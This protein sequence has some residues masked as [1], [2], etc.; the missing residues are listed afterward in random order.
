MRK[1]F[2]LLSAF[3]FAGLLQAQISNI[4]FRE[5]K[6]FHR[7]QFLYQEQS[8]WASQHTFEKYLQKENIATDEEEIAAYFAA[9]TS[10][11]NNQDGGQARLMSFQATYPR[12][13]LSQQGTWHLGSYYLSKG[14]YDKAFDYLSRR[15]LSDLPAYQQ[16]E[17]RFKLGYVNFMKDRKNQALNYL[18]PLTRHAVYGEDAKYYVGHIYYSQRKY[19][20]AQPYF[21]ELQQRNP[22]FRQ[23]LLPYMVQ[24]KFNDENYN[25]AIRLGKE[26][27]TAYQDAHLTSE[28]SK[29][30]GE[31]YFHQGQY[32][33]SIP[34]LEAY[35]GEMSAADYYQ[36]GYAYYQQK[37]YEKA[38]SLFNK[39]VAGNDKMA[40]IAYY[41]LGN[42]Y[43]QTNRKEQAL[44]AFQSAGKMDFD[45]ALQEDAYYHYAKLSYDVG[46]PYESTPVTLQK[47]LTQY[48]SG[49]HRKEIQ[50]LLV[51]AYIT[52]GDYRQA[53][54][55]LKSIQNKNTEQ[56]KTFQLANYLYATTL[57]KNGKLN[58]A[59]NYFTTARQISAND[60][61]TARAEF[62]LGEIAYRQGKYGEALN[63]F[64]GLEN[65][66][67]DFN[68]RKELSYQLGYTH[69]KLK[70]FLQSEKY[71][72]TYLA[73]NP[74]GEFKADARM[75]LADSYVG[76]RNN[77][78]A[79][80]VYE[81][82]EKSNN[83]MADEAAY[84]RAIVL[85]L[86]KGSAAKAQALEN[87]IKAYPVSKFNDQ[88]QLELADAYVD[89][90]QINSANLVLDN[91]IK[92]TNADFAAEAHLRKG[93][94]FYNQ[95]QTKEALRQFEKVTEKKPGAK[96]AI[97]AIENAKRIYLNN[98][99]YKGFERWVSRFDY[100]QIDVNEI[101]TLALD[102]ALKS[103]DANNYPAAIAALGNLLKDYP[104]LQKNDQVNYALGESYYQT[105]QWD[106]ALKPLNAAAAING[107][108]QSDALLRLAQI[109]LNKNQIT[110]AKLSLEALYNNTSNLAYQSFAEIHLM[111]IYAKENNTKAT[112]LAQKVLTNSKNE[113]SVREEAELILARELYHNGQK[114]DAEK[115]YKALENASSTAVRAEALYYKALLL[116]ERKSFEASNQV[117]FELA[118]KYADQQLWGSQAL[119]VM[120]DNYYQQGDL[121]QA[122][123][124]IESILENYKDFPEVSK[125][126]KVLQQKIKAKKK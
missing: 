5:N 85:G 66:P 30:V 67:K 21:E 78:Q 8:Y 28:I 120:A 19:D 43:L 125:K 59:K 110:E 3:G 54:E 27:L 29:I 33:Q 86:T 112:E 72:K 4:D 45:A 49:A 26:Q 92:H 11:I 48:P 62:W 68:E 50:N 17:F 122:N 102:N 58:E 117:I 6:E 88:A 23:R 7:A 100:Y 42:A 114:A 38:I 87:F 124:T 105:N 46:N 81:E 95:G 104:Q 74:P 37:N 64:K 94:I 18:K 77:E 10:L 61:M 22:V 14:D 107:N 98:S 111:R 12:S 79:V 53:V 80:A 25:E 121:Y 63:F 9:L 101:Q 109:Y 118:S 97:Q 69:Y 76:N 115:S 16:D 103:F 47:Y 39:I 55:M 65:F 123:H 90:E 71:F 15:N 36:L 2:L 34:Y 82:V 70:N 99:D 57:Y 73:T 108:Y 60:V 113:T 32:D 126:A 51:D 75:R 20:L 83:Q 84:S 119:V 13:S 40:Q 1:N 35:T 41:Q 93:F 91:L 52:S 56:N 116:N 89:L 31:S 96:Q 106:A 44:A 24:I